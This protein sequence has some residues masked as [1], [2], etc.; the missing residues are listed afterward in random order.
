MNN[1]SRADTDGGDNSKKH[2]YTKDDDDN[3]GTNPFNLDFHPIPIHL[4]NLKEQN[5]S[6]AHEARNNNSGKERSIS[7]DEK[8]SSRNFE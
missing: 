2:N 8:A 4:Y 1:N 6:T 3:S 5:G 7:Y